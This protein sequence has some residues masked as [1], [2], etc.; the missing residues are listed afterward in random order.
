MIR[1]DS[2]VPINRPFSWISI[3]PGDLTD[4]QPETGPAVAVDTGASTDDVT[5]AWMTTRWRTAGPPSAWSTTSCSPGAR[6]ATLTGATPCS[7]PSTLTS[8]PA[9]SD[10]TSRLPDEGVSGS[11]RYCEASAPAVTVTGITRG[12][13]RPRS[14]TMCE[15][16][17]SEMRAG[18][19]PRATPSTNTATPGGLVCS[20]NVPS[21]GHGG[22]RW[23]RAAITPPPPSGTIASATTAMRRQRAG[24]FVDALVWA[25]WLP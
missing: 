7:T 2:V 21:F 12:T 17:L 5:P 8:A 18:V 23:A 15:P 9:G 24:P 14:S 6:S 3:A 4:N 10:C 20:D 22:W 11:S 25:G 13:P 19:L 1:S 16:A